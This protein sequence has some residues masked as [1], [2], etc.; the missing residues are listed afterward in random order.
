[1]TI[2]YKS[3][4]VDTKIGNICSKIMYEASKKTWDNRKAL[5]GEIKTSFDDFAGL[6]FSNIKN[7]YISLNFD[8]V[9]TK[10]EIA[11]RL[12]ALFNDFS[13]HKGIAHDLF[14]MVCEDASIRGGEPILIGSILDVNKLNESIVK[15]LAEGMVEAANLANVAVMNG[16]IA[17]LGLRIGGYGEYC[18]NWGSGLIWTADKN[19]LISGYDIRKGDII[20]ALK[21]EGFRSNGFSLIRKI[22]EHKYGKEWHKENPEL[23]RQLLTPSKIYTK[24]LVELT[25]KYKPHGM[26]HITGG[27]IPEKLGRLL[28]VSKQG[29]ILDNLFEPPQAAI[30]L[31][32]FGDLKD[33]GAYNT[34]NMGNGVL[35][36]TDK[37]EETLELAKKHSIE[38]RIAGKITADKQ[39]LIKSKANFKSKAILIFKDI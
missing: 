13:F 16:E 30:I 32:Q 11:E 24:M 4:G 26:A 7:Q 10:I 25:K 39:I 21:E 9:G 8:G 1:M 17:E 6:R 22:M 14:A 23:A 38:A 19:D 36:V 3:S 5:V 12:A 18:Y 27:G 29:A 34:W 35:I 31:Q 20:I 28:R 2:T 15:A 33:E 37:P